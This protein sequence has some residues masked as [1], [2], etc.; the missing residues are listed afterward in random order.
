MRALL[1]VR[2]RLRIEKQEQRSFGDDRILIFHGC[3]YS[4]GALV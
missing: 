3:E 4:L 2:W 1:P